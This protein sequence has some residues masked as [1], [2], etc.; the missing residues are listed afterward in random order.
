MQPFIQSVKS[1]HSVGGAVK[2]CGFQSHLA[3]YWSMCVTV[4]YL[5][6]FQGCRAVISSI[7]FPFMLKKPQLMLSSASVA[8]ALSQA[9]D[10]ICHWEAVNYDIIECEVIRHLSYFSELFGSSRACTSCSCIFLEFLLCALYSL[11]KP[12]NWKSLCLA[13]SIH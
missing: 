4:N 9:K 11:V 8:S 1:S 10:N 2:V 13:Q 3:F 7:F 12:L 6:V 5:V